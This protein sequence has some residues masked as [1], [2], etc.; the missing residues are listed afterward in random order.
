MKGFRV[1]TCIVGKKEKWLKFN[2]FRVGLSWAICFSKIRPDQHLPGRCGPADAAATV[3]TARPDPPGPATATNSPYTLTSAG[4]PRASRAGDPAGGSRYCGPGGQPP[5][6]GAGP[7]T[8]RRRP[9]PTPPPLPAP[10]PPACARA[11]R[12][13]GH[14]RRAGGGGGARPQ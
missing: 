9:A 1:H 13:A 3:A 14:Q 8:A 5:P 6:R 11:R 7:A 10:P 2:H 4:P 12:G